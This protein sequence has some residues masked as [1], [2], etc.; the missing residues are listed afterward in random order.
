MSQESNH[1]RFQR[2]LTPP[3]ERAGRSKSCSYSASEPASDE[4]RRRC[5][6]RFAFEGTDDDDVMLSMFNFEAPEKRSNRTAT[7]QKESKLSNFGTEARPS[8]NRHTRNRTAKESTLSTPKSPKH[9]RRHTEPTPEPAHQ[10]FGAQLRVMKTK[11]GGYWSA[12]KPRYV[13]YQPSTKCMFYWRYEP[14]KRRGRTK[15]FENV[16]GCKLTFQ[17]GHTIMRVFYNDGHAQ[18]QLKF[19]DRAVA[20]QWAN[21][22][23]GSQ[24]PEP[25]TKLNH[26]ESY[27]STSRTASQSLTTSNSSQKMPSSTAR[28]YAEKVVKADQ[29]KSIFSTELKR[30]TS[31]RHVSRDSPFMRDP[32]P[33]H[34]DQ[35][36]L[37]AFSG[38][39]SIYV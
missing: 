23:A 35:Y 27:A 38:S 5:V 18:A 9:K 2:S 22:V 12:W 17:K 4:F 28:R 19:T 10:K 37:P 1:V 31:K 34:S 29:I 25:S 6:A 30:Q 36:P 16:V 15:C 39:G 26:S 11:F 24:V 7:A 13:E 32:A 21:A 3:R 8:K 14:A 20:E 33:A